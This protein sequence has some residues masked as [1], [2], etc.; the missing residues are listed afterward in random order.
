MTRRSVL[1]PFALPVLS[2]LATASDIADIELSEPALVA[3]T[4]EMVI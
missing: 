1:Q 4:D 2:L 3:V